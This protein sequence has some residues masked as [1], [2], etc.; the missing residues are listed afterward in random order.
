MALPNLPAQG[1]NPWYTEREAFDQAVKT[2]LDGLTNVNNTSDLNKPISTAT[3]AALNGKAAISHTHTIAQVTGLQAELDSKLT[4]DTLNASLEGPHLFAGWRMAVAEQATRTTKILCI[5]DSVTEGTGVTV[6]EDT[7]P[8]LLAAKLRDAIP[9]VP[10]NASDA[11]GWS[12]IAGS[13]STLTAPWT[14]AN[15]SGTSSTSSNFGFRNIKSQSIS[16]GATITGTVTGTS[17][18]IWHTRGTNTAAF[19]VRVDGNLIGSYGGPTG[20]VTSGYVNRVS[21]GSAGSHTVV[22]TSGAGPAYINGITV[23]NGNENAGISVLNAGVHGSQSV[24]WNSTASSTSW[25]QDI[26]TLQPDMVIIMIGLNDYS[27][28]TGRANY[29]SNIRNLINALQDNNSGYPTILLVAPYKENF[30]ASPR[31]EVYQYGLSELAQSEG[32]GFF[33]L[34][35]KMPDVGS[36]AGNASGYY[37]DAVHPS[38]LGYDKIATELANFLVERI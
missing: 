34:R 26:A 8:Y 30:V 32:V 6:L 25:L 29:M 9:S 15:N 31:W 20:A 18:D 23:F 12:P 1:Q 3:Q 35:T 10:A 36:A 28:S 33:D 13:S 7:W 16:G 14:V 21:L 2:R 38:A 11:R 37:S 5:G 24:I 19:Q 17:I 27:S 22:I 4:S